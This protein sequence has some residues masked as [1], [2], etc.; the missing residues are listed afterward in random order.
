MGE[1]KKKREEE[2]R[3]QIARARFKRWGFGAQGAGEQ[4]TS[5]GCFSFLKREKREKKKEER[6]PK[7]L[8]ELPA[9][10]LRF[11]CTCKK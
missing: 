11:C 10:P 4:P 6:K 9:S 5:P 7:L 8:A 3:R 1:K 2:R